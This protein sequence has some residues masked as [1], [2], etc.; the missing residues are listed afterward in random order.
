MFKTITWRDRRHL[1]QT[2]LPVSVGAWLL[3]KHSLTARLIKASQGDFRVELIQQSWRLPTA[4]E[5]KLLALKSREVALVREVLLICHGQ[6]WVFARS[7]I[8]ASSLRGK[9]GF[10]RK[11]KNSAL[12]AL[13]FK[14]PSLQ[15]SHFEVARI[16]LPHPHIPVQSSA[17]IYGRRSL[18]YWK[19]KPL[20]VA[21]IFLPNCRL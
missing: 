3:D 19:N 7:V 14:D 12:G 8:P 21:E 2:Q 6:P 15:R 9:L 4:D 17:N 10:L 16:Q 13:L 11:L 1:N 18:F 5:S 20:L